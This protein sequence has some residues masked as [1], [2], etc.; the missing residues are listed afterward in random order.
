LQIA[1]YSWSNLQSKIRGA[2]M[3]IEDFDQ[4]QAG[5]DHM[6]LSPH[7]DDAA[8]S[9][10]GSIAAQRAAGKRVLVVTL[11][12]AAPAPDMHFS[13]LALEFHRKWGLAPAEVVA[14]RLQEER[15][16]L[17]I[18]GADSYWAGM[19]DA[20]Y[21]YPQAYNTR[22]SLFN[23]P[24][25]ADPLL[26][27]LHQFIGDLRERAPG[28]TFYA[29]FGVGSHVDHLITHAAARD[30]LGDGLLFYEDLPYAARPGVL[31]QRLAA[32]GGRPTSRTIAIDATFDTKI[33]A[34]KAYASQLVELFGGMDGMVH[35][36]AE[37]MRGLR[38]EQGTYGERFWSLKR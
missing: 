31:D 17:E 26:P 25:P 18:L 6:Y 9:C 37:Y 33:D 23:M 4:I 13:D 5:Y 1:D 2:K 15:R 10:G 30:V 14:A 3:R 28:A 8:L 35:M 27:A 29:P 22:G 19:F 38:P 36:M 24:A 11:C 20:I 12:T 32:L 21:R 7:L 34:I 16:A